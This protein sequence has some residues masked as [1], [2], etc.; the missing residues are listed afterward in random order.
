M[1]SSPDTF[2]G[3]LCFLLLTTTMLLIVN[4]RRRS[5]LVSYYGLLGHLSF[6]SLMLVSSPVKSVSV[7]SV[8][9]DSMSFADSRTAFEFW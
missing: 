6:Q 3:L 5:Y 8:S 9:L 2:S 7:E 1:N 4:V